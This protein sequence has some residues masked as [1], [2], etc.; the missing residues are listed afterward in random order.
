MASVLPA[1]KGKFGSTEYYVLTM[2]ALELTKQL[3]IPEKIEGWDELSLEERYQREI[4]FNRVKRQIA[5]YLVS[6]P[7]R[8][9][10]AFIV[11]MYKGE[12]EFEPINNIYKGN[13]PKLYSNAAGAFGFLNFEGD[14]IL[15]P[16]DGQHRL[17]AL[18]FAITGKDQNQQ[19]IKDVDPSPSVAS[20]MCTVI[21]VGNDTEKSRKIFNKVNRYAK[22]TSKADN[23][24]TADDDIVAVIV[25]EDLIGE[26]HCFPSDVVNAKSNTLNQ[27]AREFTTLSTLYEATKSVLENTHG[28]I[29]TDRLPAVDVQRLM[30]AEAKD[31]WETIV[32]E[33]EP[34]AHLV[35]DQTENGDNHRREFRRDYVLGKPIAQWALV[36][37]ILKLCDED[38]ITGLRLSLSEACQRV[39]QL[40]W[41][42]ENERWQNVLMNGQKVMAGKATVNF[43]AI[44]IA[45]WLGKR[46][47]SET[48]ENIQIRHRASGAGVELSPPVYVAEAM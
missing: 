1:M 43:A 7:D 35:S 15:V 37:A 10:G 38:S 4:N 31:Y 13:V 29:R 16:L 45:Y 41:R 42:V 17:A 44:I 11:M 36:E 14:E 19:S 47:D 48:L 9:F 20:D 46:L 2:P 5:P 3:V 8:F 24:I 21:L 30:R 34:I 12:I 23:L 32:S 25:R 40:D 22:S 27:S 39:N 33:I 28:K 6:D 26:E 18:E